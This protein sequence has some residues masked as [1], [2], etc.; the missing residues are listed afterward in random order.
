MRKT[1]MI[2]VFSIFVCTF[3]SCSHG[4]LKDP[5]LYNP[6]RSSAQTVAPEPELQLT[7]GVDPFDN[8]DAWYNNPESNG[9]ETAK[10]KVGFSAEEFNEIQITGWFSDLNVPT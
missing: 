8:L 5:R 1:K 3:M 2:A 10:E 6:K 9:D 7:G 4:V